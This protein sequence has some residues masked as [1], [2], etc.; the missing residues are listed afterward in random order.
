M[1]FLE[2]QNNRYAKQIARMYVRLNDLPSALKWA[3]E[4]TYIDLYDLSSHELINEIATQLG[5]Q[6]TADRA[7]VTAE[8]IKLWDLKRSLPKDQTA[9]P[10]AE[11]DAGTKP[12]AEPDA[13]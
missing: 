10:N 5:D 6:A 9:D 11:K 7:R 13:Q 12:D 1:H 2:L 4:A 3:R 8:R